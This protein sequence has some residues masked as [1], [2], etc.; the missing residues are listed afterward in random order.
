MGKINYAY[1]LEN[2]LRLA[3]S[4]KQTKTAKCLIYTAMAVRF[5]NRSYAIS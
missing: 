1:N 3:L 4:K 5:A 2:S